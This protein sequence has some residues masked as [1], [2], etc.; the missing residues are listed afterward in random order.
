ML[1]LKEKIYAILV[2]LAIFKAVKKHNYPLIINDMYNHY[3][4]W[5]KFDYPLVYQISPHLRYFLQISTYF[6]L[7]PP[8]NQGFQV[9]FR[10]PLSIKPPLQLERGVPLFNLKKSEKQKLDP[11]KFLEL[12]NRE[13]RE[14]F[15]KKTT[16]TFFFRIVKGFY[17]FLPKRSF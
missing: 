9:N 7:L 4:E 8:P 11:V 5:Y 1:T 13:N 2:S 15:Y 3:N 14:M 12:A 10:S 16:L 17:Y 6:N